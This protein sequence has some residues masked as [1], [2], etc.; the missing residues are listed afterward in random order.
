VIELEPSGNV[1][2]TGRFDASQV[3]K[4]EAVLS[5]VEGSVVA[6]LQGLAYISSAGIGSLVKTLKRL[7]ENGDSFKLVNLSPAIRNIFRY[8]GLDQIFVIE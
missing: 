5:Q 3:A 1:T 8:A 4:A 2:M 6:D 7:Q